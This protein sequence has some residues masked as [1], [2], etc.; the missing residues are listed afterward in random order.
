MPFPSQC[1]PHAG[2]VH[3]CSMQNVHIHSFPPTI[4]RNALRKYFQSSSIFNKPMHC[5]RTSAFVLASVHAAKS[6]NKVLIASCGAVN[7]IFDSHLFWNC[8]GCKENQRSRLQTSQWLSTEAT[9][10]DW[11]KATSKSGQELF[12]DPAVFIRMQ[13]LCALQQGTHFMLCYCMLGPLPRSHLKA[14]VAPLSVSPSKKV[15]HD[16]WGIDWAC[17]QRARTST[18]VR[19]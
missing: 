4:I 18:R 13:C 14:A 10:R 8:D 16:G 1:M 6:S 5:A 11:P 17:R 9:W 3:L 15:K 7:D 12:G 2:S 19:E